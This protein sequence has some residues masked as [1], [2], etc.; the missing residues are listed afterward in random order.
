MFKQLA[1]HTLT[2]RPLIS[3]TPL[4]HRSISRITNSPHTGTS[5]SF[6]D[7][8]SQHGAAYL[9]NK[10][11]PGNS[12]RF[13]GAFQGLFITKMDPDGTAEATLEITEDLSNSYGTSLSL[14]HKKTT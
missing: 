13:D 2:L 10:P 9:V 8:A 1:K 4:L 14:S 3:Q 5:G 11:F 7:L 6:I 12:S